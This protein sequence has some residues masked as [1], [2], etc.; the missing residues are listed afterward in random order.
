MHKTKYKI[1]KI[2]EIQLQQFEYILRSEDTTLNIQVIIWIPSKRN[3][4]PIWKKKV[5]ANIWKKDMTHQ[6]WVD[7]KLWKRKV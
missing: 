5:L 1:Q 4:K 3:P 6:D 2:K 7:R